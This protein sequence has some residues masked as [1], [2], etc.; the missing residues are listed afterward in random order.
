MNLQQ[1]RGWNNK[2][3]ILKAEITVFI[4]GV[5][6]AVYTQEEIIVA[7][8]ESNLWCQFQTVVTAFCQPAL[9]DAFGLCADNKENCPGVLDGSFVPHKD[10]YHYAVSLLETMVQPQSLRD[11]GPINCIPTPVK[12]VDAW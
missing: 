9:F 3:S 1:I 7:A 12:N 4:N 8:V 10:P 11:R 5:I 2:Q 6:T